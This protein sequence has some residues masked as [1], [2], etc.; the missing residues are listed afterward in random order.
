MH[1]L[2]YLLLIS[3]LCYLLGRRMLS[4]LGYVHG[5]MA[6][7]LLLSV[8]GGLGITALYMLLLGLTG[9]MYRLP[10]ILY[11][12]VILPLLLYFGGW[13]QLRALLSGVWGARKRIL[14]AYWAVL[15]V[16]ILYALFRLMNC[17]TPVL[18]GDSTS[19][20]LG[21]PK[22]YIE[23]GSILNP[24]VSVDYLSSNLPQ[25]MYMLSVFGMLL[26][27]EILS[28][29]ILGWLCGMLSM[30]AVYVIS[31]NFASRQ[32]S[33]VMAIIFFT[34][35]TLS[36]L[37]YSAK[38]DLGFTMFELSFWV[39]LIKYIRSASPRDLFISAIFLGFA[40]GSKYHGLIALTFTAVVIFIID[41]VRKRKF[42][43]VIGTIFVFSVITLAIG[44][45]SYI[46]SLLMVRDPFFPFLSNPGVVEGE[47][48]NIYKTGWDYFRFLYNMVFYRDFLIRPI[49]YADRAIGFL[50]V[51]FLPF[52]LCCF[53]R[54]SQLK[55]Q[56]IVVFGVYFVLLSMAICWSVWPFPR[57]FLPAI[58][59][60][61]ATG[62][63]GLAHMNRII[64]RRITLPV[65]TVCILAMVLTM[66]VSYS[67]IDRQIKYLS[68]SIS[69]QHYLEQVLFNNGRHMNSGMLAYVSVMDPAA[70][71][72]TLDYGN[73]FYVPRPFLKKKY[74]YLISDVEELMASLKA[75]GFSHVYYSSTNTAMFVEKFNSGRQVALL[76]PQNS[77]LLSV[78]Y[79]SGDQ[80]LLRIDYDQN[81]TELPNQD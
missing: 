28:Q 45:P 11:I 26:E 40:V 75:D 81:K 34:M 16:F 60:M 59:L 71:I 56:L 12:S 7:S 9:M 72:V 2:I 37:I 77:H 53:R 8:T 17:L 80:Y 24:P 46:K 62:A 1:N 15:A 38:L 23:N 42:W 10:V 48:F 76:E 61:T 78:Q 73:G 20:Y 55:R 63:I 31:R 69:K 30:L 13:R 4:A 21:I 32:I 3:I 44:S 50:P 49:S 36:W 74:V 22:L 70:R 19:W 66:N 27:S 79:Q 33:L 51:M 18:D 64:G 47:G 25:N 5:S 41:L 14:P 57:H 65:V 58:G 67:K 6:E 43:K 29:L 52:L 54:I 68:G 35:P 39:L